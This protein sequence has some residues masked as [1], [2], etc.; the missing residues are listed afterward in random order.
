MENFI[1]LKSLCKKLIH[2]VPGVAV[3]APFLYEYRALLSTP[4]RITETAPCEI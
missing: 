1:G 3:C 4:A 2:W